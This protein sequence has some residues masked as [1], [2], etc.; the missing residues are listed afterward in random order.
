MSMSVSMSVSV[1]VSMVGGEGDGSGVEVGMEM[2]G[3]LRM[4]R[5]KVEGFLE[6]V[7]G[8]VQYGIGATVMMRNLLGG[9][10]DAGS[11][12]V[13]VA[14]DGFYSILFYSML[15]LYVQT[16]NTA[17]QKL[18]EGFSS[19]SYLW[20]L[21]ESGAWMCIRKGGCLYSDLMAGKEHD[22]SNMPGSGRFV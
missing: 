2:C 19:V 9:A 16:R 18:I 11:K 13:E 12:E 22:G 3:G 20:L 4:K 17:F 21:F 1:S 6:V 10:Q 5:D 7:I 8:M 15:S 14:A